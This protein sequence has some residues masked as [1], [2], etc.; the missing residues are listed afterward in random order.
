LKGIVVIACMTAAL[1]VLQVLALKY[2]N[3]VQ[4]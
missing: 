3:K 1:R 4:K 2:L